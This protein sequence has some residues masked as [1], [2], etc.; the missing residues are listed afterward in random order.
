M[1]L[2]GGCHQCKS[3]EDA[4]F[5]AELVLHCTCGGKSS[6]T[7]H[8]LDKEVTQMGL[9]CSQ[10]RIAF[11]MLAIRVWH[12]APPLS[13]LRPNMPSNQRGTVEACLTGTSRPACWL[14]GWSL[15]QHANT[16]MSSARCV[17]Q[18]ATQHNE[19]MEVLACCCSAQFDN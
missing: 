8:T 2:A 13:S 11:W 5:T 17:A 12:A 14:E 4:W 9:R 19:P 1:H 18:S 7:L 16:C 15:E 3:L 10:S 6:I